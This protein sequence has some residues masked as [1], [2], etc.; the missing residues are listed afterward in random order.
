MTRVKSNVKAAVS[1]LL[2]LL[3][4]LALLQLPGAEVSAATISKTSYTLTKGY[5]TTLKV[6]GNTSAVTWSSS[7]SAVATVSS[8][9]KVVG[10]S[11]GSANIY[12][13]VD[14]SRLTCAVTVVGGKL[15][16][17]AKTVTIDE[18]SYKYVTVRAKGSHGLK[19]TSS[20]TSIASGSWVK[21]WKD[22]DIRL[23]I[24]GKKAGTANIKIILTKYPDVAVNISVTVK[25]TAKSVLEVSQTSLST[26]LD[27]PSSL[28]VY[29]DRSNSLNYTLS[30]T[31]VAKVQEGAWNS[32]YCTLTITG[33]KAGTTNLTI[34]H[35]DDAT[36][37]KVIPITVTGSAYYMVS[38]A[39]MSKMAYTDQ[40]YQWVDKKTSRY[41]YMLV[42][43]NY[44]I[45][46]VNTAIAK[47]ASSYE[48]YTV[49]EE[50]P[51]SKQ[52]ST[53]T[54][55]NFKAVVNNQ[56]VTRYV[57][58]PANP[59]TPSLNTA[60]ASYTKQFQYWTVYNVDP[61][62]GKYRA[63][64]VVQSWLATVNY[65]SQ[66]RYILL[67]YGY[68]TA[69]LERIIAADS[70]SVA[71]G[72][73]AASL[74]QP[75]QKASTDKILNFQAVVNNAYVTYYV[76]V[77]EN[78]D[79]ARYNDVV[80][81]YTG[82]YDYYAIYNTM[83]TKKISIDT[84]D[85]WTKVVDSKVTTRYMLLPSGYDSVYATELKNKDMA[86]Q[87]SNYYT[88]T[89]VRPTKI[90]STDVIESFYNPSTGVLK[91]MLVPAN[92]NFVKRN[93]A[94]AKDT[95]IYEYYTMYSTQ[96][97]KKADTD[98]ILPVTYP[99]YGTVYVLLPQNYDQD[100]LNQGLSGVRT[101]QIS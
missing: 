97:G 78:Y 39:V 52:V 99:S 20:D 9:G 53:D 85:S 29:S 62:S 17:S 19:A 61:S 6:T 100:K 42:P 87:T 59:D 64:D 76:L 38:D 8:S 60:V 54:V 26:K 94:I 98:S 25:S 58:V 57:L 73:Y 1:L 69:R 43:A 68:D 81:A 83:P 16:L 28:M 7:N 12:A 23:K 92:C 32:N 40:I 67:P 74:T 71:G 18:G 101:N 46:K 31:T 44:D 2:A 55:Q 5:S 14:G 70:G 45:A 56:E 11:A 3:M 30:D 86:T 89:T 37:K 82:S 93:D 21:P 35:K 49:Y 50:S 34:T 66:T 41:K 65:R 22:D 4:A 79:E 48:Y 84:I 75:V 10:K 15:A 47:D 13:D 33:L 63:D 95:G 96:P 80:A 90:E 91:Y 77:P 51:A 24:S 27:T 72:Y 36:V 88:V